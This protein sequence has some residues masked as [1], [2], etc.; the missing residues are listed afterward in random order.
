MEIKNVL[1]FLI[2]FKFII[3]Y[4]L[5]TFLS[6]LSFTSTLKKNILT[7]RTGGDYCVQLHKDQL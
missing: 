5:N 1:S 3:S 6:F 7:L 4:K 2:M